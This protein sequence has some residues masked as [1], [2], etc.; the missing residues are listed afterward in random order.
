[1]KIKKIKLGV[2][3]VEQVLDVSEKRRA[4]KRERGAKNNQMLSFDD[5]KDFRKAITPKRVELLHITKKM[6]PK[7][8]QELA[9]ILERDIKSVATDIHLLGHLGLIEMKRKTEG[10]KEIIPVVDYIMINL[11]IVI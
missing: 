10:R 5:I 2:K 3:G 6:Q 8:M 4:L 9:R 1:M 11:E 7:S